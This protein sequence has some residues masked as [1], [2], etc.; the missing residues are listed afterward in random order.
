MMTPPKA[1]IEIMNLS[2]RKVVVG[3]VMSDEG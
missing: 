1:L 3:L 2:L